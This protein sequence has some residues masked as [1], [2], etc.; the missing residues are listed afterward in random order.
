MSTSAKSRLVVCS[1]TISID[2]YGDGPKQDSKNPLGFGGIGL[3]QWAFGTRTIQKI[4]FG[5]SEGAIGPDD[6]IA[7][8][9]F[10]N[11]GA[12]IMGRNMFGPIRGQWEDDSW[13]GWWGD[14][15]PYHCPVF[16]LTH[17][18]RAPITM[19][20][21]TVFYFVTEGIQAAL[22]QARQAA[23]GKNARLGGGVA[24]IQEYL[25]APGRRYAH[26]NRTYSAWLG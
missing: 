10:E 16:V 6:D 22:Q 4:L 2:G 18:A 23:N 19:K 13:N 5:N 11:I 25:R 7:A 20:G 21:G 17:H 9:G 8:R 3:H 26:C 15:P 1:F 14:E 24:T 12:W